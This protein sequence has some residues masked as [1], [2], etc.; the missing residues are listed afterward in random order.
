MFKL[1]GC[2]LVLCST[3]FISCQKVLEN[4]YTYKFLN[5]IYHT[6]RKI[7][8]ENSI[9][10]PYSRIFERIK[11][12]K[13][14]YMT[15]AKTNGY[16]NRDEIITVQMFFDNLGKRDRMAECEYIS[17]NKDNFKARAQHYLEDY[18]NIKKT[19]LLC[20]IACGLFIIIF[21]I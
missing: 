2:L 1:A 3:V 16:I 15:K 14:D 7:Q 6:V 17:Q 4:Y 12:K 13:D 21:L 5:D 20:G 8:Y 18:N 9:N 10:M 11:F 19:H